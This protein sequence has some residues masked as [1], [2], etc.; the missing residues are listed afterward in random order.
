M[1]LELIGALSELEKER[2]ISKEIL[3]DAIETAVVSAYKRNY[4]AN[5][6]MSVRVDINPARLE[7]CMFILVVK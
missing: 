5:S 6:S 2:G 1:N 4:G 7:K 3:L